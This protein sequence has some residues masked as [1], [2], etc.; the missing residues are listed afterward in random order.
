MLKR[1]LFHKLERFTVQT[2]A[3][4]LRRWGQQIYRAGTEYTGDNQHHDEL[5][6]SLRWV[7]INNKVFP[8]LL[9]ADW[10]APNATVI[11]DVE[12][13]SGS[14][15][16]HTAIVRGDTAKVT[17]GKNSLI[18][19]RTV[20]KSSSKEGSEV[21][22]GNNVFVGPN[23]H[24]DACTLDDYWYIGMGAT[25]HKGAYVEP[26]AVVAA[27]AVVQEGA[28]V[29]SGQVWAGSPARYLR[30]VTQEEKHQIAE[31]LI[32]QQQLSQIYWEETEKTFRE[33]QDTETHYKYEMNMKV[34][35]KVQSILSKMGMPVTME[36]MEYI[37]HRAL[38]QYKMDTI[39]QEV[40]DPALKE[41]HEDVTWNPYEQDLSK[42]PEIFKMYGENREKY[43]RVKQKFDTEKK[44]QQQGQHPMEPQQPRDFSPWS[45][46]YNEMMER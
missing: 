25:I 12:F 13:A 28:V 10:I 33:I 18:Q 43:E 24:I 3:P 46:K 37:E 44:G 26:Y 38:S 23:W 4:T 1:V 9:S 34:S 45:K 42:F 36:D 2:F 21:K 14:S 40:A 32:E 22:I 20:V 27:G 15:L 7:P 19:D 29:P 5:V 41:D 31:Y 39:D 8:K 17:V 11:G 35:D 6:K 16:W 30:D